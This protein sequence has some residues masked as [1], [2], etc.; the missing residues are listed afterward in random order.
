[1]SMKKYQPLFE[2]EEAPEGSAPEAPPA[3]VPPPEEEKPSAPEPGFYYSG[4]L[5]FRSI[6]SKG[7]CKSRQSEGK[8]NPY[9]SITEAV[10][11]KYVIRGGK[12]KQVKV[13]TNPDRMRIDPSTGKEVPKTGSWKQKN[14]RSQKL[15]ARKRKRTQQQAI[16]KA[17]RSK[18]RHTW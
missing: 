7:V 5:G 18:Q 17:K 6:V 4:D 10:K 11:K 13:S 3:E 9:K 16:R 1:M 12:K 14:R 15:G 8:L 2:Q